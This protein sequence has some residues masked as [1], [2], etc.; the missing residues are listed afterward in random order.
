M[1]LK[2]PQCG[3]E[4]SNSS[5]NDAIIVFQSNPAS[6]RAGTERLSHH[7]KNLTPTAHRQP[8]PDER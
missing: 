2:Q 8:V 6:K 1:A 5:A 7:F 3:G 4:S